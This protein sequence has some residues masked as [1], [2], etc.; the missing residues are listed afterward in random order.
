[1]VEPL[2][3]SIGYT[4]FNGDDAASLL[5]SPRVYIEAERTYTVNFVN[6]GPPGEIDV[7]LVDADYNTWYRVSICL[8]SRTRVLRLNE[9]HRSMG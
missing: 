4:T 9:V 7:K 8:G 3:N 2:T 5:G 1:M 6:G